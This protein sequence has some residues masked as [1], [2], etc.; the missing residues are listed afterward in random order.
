MAR[1]IPDS[2][3][4]FDVIVVGSG[5]TGGWAAKELTEAGLRVALVEAGRN[6]V[7]EKDFTEHVLPYQVKYR[8]RSPEIIRTRPIQ[9]R[10]Y[11]CM[12]YNYEWF[13]NDHENPYT[14]PPDKP[15]NWFR[16]RILGGRSLVWGRQSYRLSDLD[17]KAAS[18]D[19]YGDDWP[20]SY[21]ELAPWYDKVEQFVGISGAAEGMPQLHD[22]KFLPPM[23]MTC[24]EIMLRKAVKEKFG[25]VVTIGRAAHLTV[26]LNGRA[27]C[28]YCGP[29]ERG[30]ISQSYFNSPSTTIAAARATGRLT[31]ITDAVVSQVTTDLS[32]GRARGIRYV[33]RVTRDNRELRGKIVI[34]CAQSL[35]STRILFNSAT[36]QFPNGL[37]NSSGV[38]GHYLMDHVTG[39]G[40]S[41]IMPMLET[42]PWAGP[43]RRPNGIYLMRFRNVT[44]RHP[45][46]IRGY[47]YQGG[48][49]AQFSFEAEGFGKQFKEQVKRGEWGISLGGFGECLARWDNYCELDK[50]LVDAWGIPAL[51]ISASY[52]EN[53][54]KMGEDMAVAAAEMLETSGAKNI[55][56][57]NIIDPFGHAIHEVGTARMGNDPKKS[58][59]NKYCQ[60]HD[61]KNLF[62]MDGSCYVSSA[63]QNPT[64]TMMA[65][66]CH[67]CSYVIAQLKKGEI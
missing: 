29:C 14:T 46:F 3:E 32:T 18:R 41:G 23:P 35:E 15:F 50:T 59:L 54:L 53:E 26:P 4:V 44:D 64:L 37:V 47:G 9:S 25:R 20:I 17:F 62:V 67:S 63:C 28:H 1:A 55:R 36:R 40:A 7:P 30:C 39:F 19:G 60:A 10:C 24:G 49:H 12:E 65:I 34:L 58:V 48:S 61:V 5:A 13:V 22:S 8:G 57:Q 21:A 33:H 11:A 51:R 56:L 16:L 43:P 42:R 38:L 66:V 45:N 27:P 6:L 31:L 2:K 52:G